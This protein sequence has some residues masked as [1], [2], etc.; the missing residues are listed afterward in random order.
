MQTWLQRVERIVTTKTV[1]PEDVK[2][3]SLWI[4]DPISEFKDVIELRTGRIENGPKDIFLVLDGIF[5]TKGVEDHDIPLLFNCFRS[6]CKR[7]NKL[8]GIMPLVKDH[9]SE[10]EESCSKLAKLIP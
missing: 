4:T 7:I 9:C 5:F 10:A 2:L 1:Q 8:H 6:I 3:A